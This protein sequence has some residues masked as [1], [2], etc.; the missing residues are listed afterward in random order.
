MPK[1]RLLRACFIS[2]LD[3]LLIKRTVLFLDEIVFE[4]NG[5]F[6]S[7]AVICIG[8]LGTPNDRNGF[9][10]GAFGVTQD[11]LDC[12]WRHVVLNFIKV[13]LREH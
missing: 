10:L 11:C 1:N 12:L 6:R 4:D 13:G 7:V 2:F 5:Y 8:R 9:R 3:L